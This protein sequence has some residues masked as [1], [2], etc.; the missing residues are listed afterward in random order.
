MEMDLK[1][2]KAL[3]TGGS[4]GIGLAVAEAL[5]AE[6]CEL[7]LAA[8]GEEALKAAAEALTSEFGVTVKTHAVDLTDTAAVEA[9]GQEH[10][11]VDILINNVGG[12]PHGQLTDIDAGTWRAG[13][14]TKVFTTI[15]LTRV[16]YGAMCERG[17]GV[18]VNV[19][20]L[21]ADVP[22]AHHICA[23]TANAAMA[24][25]TRALGGVGPAN[26]VRVVGVNPGLVQTDRMISIMEPKAQE[27]LGDGSRWGELVG[28]LPFGRAAYPKEIADVVAFLASD[29]ASYLSGIV[30]PIDAGF[31][32][33]H[34]CF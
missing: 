34:R 6:G 2:R 23:S 31:S 9:L 4:K 21:A 15:D 13:W 30:I 11:Y 32:V 26:G 18:I 33:S 5:A 24:M 17:S 3:I 10:Q 1:G 27:E 8:R 7:H 25:L 28:H 12:T 16:I 20:G 19:V 22:D 29:R 14:E